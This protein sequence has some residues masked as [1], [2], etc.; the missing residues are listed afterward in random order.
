M[1]NSLTLALY[2][3]TRARSDRAARRT[4]KA[5]AAAGDGRQ[6][7]RLG[8][9][10]GETTAARPAGGPLVW[11]HTGADRH[12]LAARELAVRMRA[13]RADLSFLLTTGADRRK[14]S[15]TGL[16]SQ[17]APDDALP[18]VRRFLG[19]WQPDAAIFTEPDLRPALIT[20]AADRG[21][22][23]FLVDAQTA[24]PDPQSWRWRRG[25][26]GSLLA[27]FRKV[28]TGDAEAAAALRRLGAMAQQIEISGYLEEGTPALPCNEAER[29]ALAAGLAGRP[30]WLA[31]Y[32]TNDECA[33]VI[34]AHERAL[35]RSH[36]LLLIL[37]PGD[38]AEGVAWA[39]RL[40]ADG[41]SVA[42]R[43][44]GEE[45]DT[46]TRIYIADTECEMG[47]WYRLAPISFM[48]RSLSADG[49]ANP[50]EPAAL[51]SAILHGPNVRNFRQ[52]YARLGSAGATRLV[53]NARDLAGAVERLLSPDTA[54]AMAHA[55]WQVGS[56]GAEV[57]DRVRDL[58][59]AELDA[60]EGG[61]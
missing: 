42:L 30:V 8:E 39:R 56:S 23:L 20:E 47:L 3:A 27:R 61:G 13:D 1:G 16:I 11:I 40:V 37:V 55:A 36:R 5:D 54:A 41:N 46:E 25:M 44:A 48:G 34:D 29:D 17:L 4:L 12:G 31:A 45:P 53:R 57:T 15:D 18:A 14:A 22:P 50:F 43:S 32:V 35:R 10:L 24:R 19:H 26:S 52:A 9:R 60:R 51:G 33:A 38:R 28:L 2:L 6:R 49:G 21:I 58:I 59:F 7:E